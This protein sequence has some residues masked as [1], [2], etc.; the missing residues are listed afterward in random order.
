[1]FQI[2]NLVARNTTEGRVL[3]K[4]LEKLENIRKDMG[5]RIYDVVGKYT[6][7]RNYTTS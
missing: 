3:L 7:K 1:M 4:L 5:D 6:Q 2:Y